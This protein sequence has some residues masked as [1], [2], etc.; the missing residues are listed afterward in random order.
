MENI[1][2][3]IKYFCYISAA[4]S[5]VL[6][7][8]IDNIKWG[9]AISYAVT[10]TTILITFYIKKVWKFNPFEKYPRLNSKYKGIIKTEKFGE[11]PVEVEVKHDLIYTYVKLKTEESISKSKAFN[12]FKDGEDW[13]LIYSYLNEPGVFDRSHSDIHYG[14]CILDISNKDKISGKYYTDRKT[15]GEIEL[16]SVED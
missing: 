12:I 13:M 8:F 4:I 15:V 7:V 1:K 9:N 5:V 14:T 10:I 16:T 3:Y 2:K 11:R 6:I